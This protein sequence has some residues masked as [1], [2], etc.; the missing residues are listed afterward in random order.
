[1]TINDVVPL[2]QCAT[3]GGA[4]YVSALYS[5]TVPRDNDDMSSPI[6][7]R[8]ELPFT[9]A[10]NSVDRL[11]ITVGPDWDGFSDMGL[12]Y[13]A[14][15][16]LLLADGSVVELGS[17]VL[18]APIETATVVADMDAGTTQDSDCMRENVAAVEA[19]M[20]TPAHVAPAL[21]EFS[22]TMRSRGFAP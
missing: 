5:I 6:S 18:L 3:G 1:V 9:V 14:D 2:E 15:V 20:A 16:R 7:L 4:V 22:S 10:G 8:A 12:V 19:A 11:A 21:A 17:F 13:H